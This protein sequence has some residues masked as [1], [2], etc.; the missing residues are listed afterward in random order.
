MFFTFIF[1]FIFC[2]IIASTDVAGQ[3]KKL[4]KTIRLVVLQPRTAEWFFLCTKNGKTI[5]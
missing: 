2:N 1:V 3:Q 4:L 5:Y